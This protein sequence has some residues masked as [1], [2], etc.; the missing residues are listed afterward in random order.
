MSAEIQ[1]QLNTRDVATARFS[2]AAQTE[3]A[4]SAGHES[5]DWACTSRRLRLAVLDCSGSRER[6]AVATALTLGALRNARRGR[7]PPQDQAS[8]IDQAVWEQFAGAVSVEAVLVD[9]DL[10][11][12]SGAS[13]LSTGPMGLFRERGGTVSTPEVGAVPP[14]AMFDRSTYSGHPLDVT[15]GDRL[16]VITDGSGTLGDGTEEATTDLAAELV[17]GRDR[18]SDELVRHL[19]RAVEDDPSGDA[20]AVCI[21]LHAGARPDLEGPRR[22]T[23]R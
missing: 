16:V 2:I 7:L 15:A 3:P 12:P 8:L 17:H 22:V 14:L 1:R 23:G 4:Y 9:I 13:I 21:E 6:A 18:H 11:N 20:T 10:G 19:L 5:C